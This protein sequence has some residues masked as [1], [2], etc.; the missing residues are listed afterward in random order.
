MATPDAGDAHPAGP[1]GPS[2]DSTAA[3]PRTGA[4]PRPAD[5]R[6]P[7]QRSARAGDAAV[8]RA[9]PVPAGR[10]QT[11]PV[12]PVDPPPAASAADGWWGADAD[13]QAGRAAQDA[14]APA[15]RPAR[16]PL[17][18]FLLLVAGLVA[19]GAA[20]APWSTLV[21]S[22]ERRTFSGLTVGD[23]RVTL[24]LGAALTLLGAARLARR[25]LSVAD[26]ALSPL[27][28]G[29]LVVIAGCDLLIGPPTLATFRG[30]SADRIIVEPEIGLYASLA[31]GAVALLAAIALRR[32][33]HAGPPRPAGD[34]R[35][36]AVRAG[37]D[38]RAGRSR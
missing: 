8:A 9:E 30:I 6:A 11:V 10:D 31:A 34:D 2:P 4:R 25:R 27:L 13:G 29:L 33:G 16:R 38:H 24:V 22:D 37:G 1:A 15:A 3:L 5:S 32:A 23:G 12:E 17:P 20:F 36:P 26:A 14:A 7:E 18:S 28:A 21:A 19:V 35:P